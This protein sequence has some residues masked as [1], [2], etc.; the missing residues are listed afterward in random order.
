MVS[1]AVS[2]R[3]Y[4]KT[5]KKYTG[6]VI[7]LFLM[8]PQ[9]R[10]ITWEAPEYYFQEKGKDWY[11]AVTIIFIALVIAAIIFDNVLF[12]LLLAVSGIVLAM[13]AAKRPAV[14]PFAI[15]V[16]GIKIS[17]QLLPYDTL[18]SYYINEEN[19]NG[20]ELLILTKKRFTPII[21]IP[22]PAEYIDDVE[23]IV[24]SRLAENFLEE[25]LFMKIL[26]RLGF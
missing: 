15:S 17:D 5:F 10:A 24:R 20:P 7:Q 14:V 2:N 12:A 13:G 26:E 23:D 16:R 18:R 11:F 25:P 9:A 4:Q 21:V 1:S 22:L 8:E 6:A 3:Y 19:P